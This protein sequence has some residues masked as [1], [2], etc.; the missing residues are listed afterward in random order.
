MRHRSLLISAISVASLACAAHAGSVL[1]DWNVIVRG[2]VFSTSEV[3]GSALIGGNLGGS[4]S[5]YAVQGVTASNGDGLAVAGNIGVNVQIN[6]GGNLRLGGAAFGAVNLN[7]VGGTQINDSAVSSMVTSAINQVVA[8]QASLSSLAA[9]GTIDGAGN[10][11]ASPTNIGGANVAV[12]S[13]NIS[14]IQSF[15]Q[16]NLNMGSADTVILNVTSNNGVIDL[17]APPNLL[18]GFNQNNSSKILWNFVDATEI[19]V[20]N[21]FNGALIAPDADLRILGGA[22]NGT[23]VVGSISQQDAEIRRH[24]Y[25]GWLPP[26]D[27]PPVIPLP[28]GGAMAMAGLFAIGARR[29][30]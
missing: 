29:R 23:V 27:E 7:G 16:L 9:N 17:V 26:Q 2:N 25:T 21:T 1:T 6:N 14:T 30:R 13:F 5:N 20:N 24:T 15:G 22:I 18:G 8:M 28:A 12:Y 19:T 10:M 11:N 3:D 4:A